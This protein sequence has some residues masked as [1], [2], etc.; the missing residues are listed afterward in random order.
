MLIISSFKK[1]PGTRHKNFYK[2]LNL[3]K[4]KKWF[5]FRKTNHPIVG[6]NSKKTL[7]RRL[8][9]KN[10]LNVKK[11]QHYDKYFS[12]VFLGFLPKQ[13][14]R[15]ELGNY[16]NI[17]GLER[18]NYVTKFHYPGFVE[19]SRYIF[20]AAQNLKLLVGQTVPINLVPI[21]FPI[22]NI[23]NFYN[24]NPTYST[25]FGSSSIRQKNLKKS[26]LI[27]ILLP[28][29]NIKFFP[30]STLVC[31]GEVSGIDNNNLVEGK[32]G[33]SFKFF[34]KVTVRGVAKNPVDHPNGGRTKAKQPELSPWGWVSKFNK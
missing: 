29:K 12:S 27:S 26:K 19:F 21:N 7:R 15:V 23:Y 28:S 20:Y 25:S 10:I 14:T 9:F 1:T 33:F 5:F 3:N 34:K 16:I 32:W 17:Y 24:N 2:I 11:F 31:F 4:F 18:I 22:S 8:K 30:V 13:L 6:F